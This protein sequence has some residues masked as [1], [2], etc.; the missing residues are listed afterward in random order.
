MTPHLHAFTQR[1]LRFQLLVLVV[2]A[3]A[4]SLAISIPSAL[5]I[6]WDLHKGQVT[7]SLETTARSAAIAVSAA[8]AFEDEKAAGEALRI[9]APQKEIEAAAVYQLNGNRLAVYGDAARLPGDSHQLEEHAPDISPLSGSAT[10]LLPIILDDAKLGQIYLRADLSE[11][12]DSYLK[13]SLLAILAGLLGLGLA[14]GFGLR[15]IGRIT[16]PVQGLAGLAHKVRESEDFSLRAAAP[17]AGGT[18]NEISELVL[19]FNAMLAEL[20]KRERDLGEYQRGLENRVEERTRQLE[21]ANAALQVEIRVRERSEAIVRA[22]EEKLRGLFEL[23]PLGILLVDMQGRFLEFNEAFRAI[24]GYPADELRDLDFWALTPDKY[25]P[26]EDAQLDSLRRSGRYGPYEKEY[27]RKDGSR[28]P[29]NLN[30]RLVTGADGQTYIWSIVEDISARKQTEAE[31]LAQK[32]SAE[33]ANQ[34]KSRFLAAASHDLRQPMHALGLLISALSERLEATGGGAA[35]EGDAENRRLLGL[36]DA[37]VRNMGNLLNDL[38]DLSRLDAGVVVPQPHCARVD[39][40]F[41]RLKSRFQPL[42]SDKNLRLVFMPCRLAVETDPI[43]FD[44]I[45]A[46]LI[47]NA[48]RYTSTGGILVG[49]RRHGEDTLRIEVIDT[50]HGIPEAM[51]GRIFEEYFQLG[52]PERDR[53]KGLGLGLNIVKRLVVLLGIH[54]EMSSCLGHGTRFSLELPRCE[55]KEQEQK[56]ERGARLAPMP[57]Q[58][59]LVVLV[60]DDEAILVAVRSLFEQWGIDL[61]A[62][63]SLEAAKQALATSGRR[64]NLILSDYRLPGEHDGIGVVAQFRADYGEELPAVLITGDTGKAAMEAIT[65]SGLKLMHKPLQPAKLRA[66]LTY[67]LA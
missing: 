10:L 53:D 58:G 41:G 11:Y 1:S 16:R 48:I 14:I 39:D 12:R 6:A 47:A 46:N 33:E 52:N 8:V 29:I 36:I 32:R 60:D 66:L 18:N 56:T 20:E 24:C 55:F 49:V 21:A 54:I 44:R 34:A 45:L 9:L 27:I 5:V 28:V 59:K 30:G 15:I 35:A 38:L 19:S 64:P 7:R 23:A 50:G 2:G 26:D 51:F 63:P 4:L 40:V 22:S 31:M 62:A 17:D 25:L 57:G 3:V 65:Q 67:L 13:Q 43:L 61:I 37:S 42:A